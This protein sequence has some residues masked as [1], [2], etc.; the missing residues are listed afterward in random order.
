MSR[1]W[2]SAGLLGLALLS[3]AV[4]SQGSSRPAV[5]VP[6]LV[7]RAPHGEAALDSLRGQVVLVDFWASWCAPCEKSFPWL[8]AMQKRFGPRGFAV[9]AVSVDKSLNA[10]DA[11]VARHPVS[12]R[13][14]YDPAGRAATAFGVMGMPSTFLVGRDGTILARHV[15][16]DPRRT[17]ALE[18]VIEEALA[19]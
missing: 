13:I 9:L 8:D 7:L 19:R 11:F 10:A 14:A 12:F 2:L 6:S 4:V 15:G 17:S 18:T 1:A 3:T 16:F 5:Q